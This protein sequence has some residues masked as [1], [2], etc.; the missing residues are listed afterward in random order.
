MNEKIALFGFNGEAMCFV[1]VLLNAL[2]MHDKGN[3]V[4][5]VVEGASVKALVEVAAQGHPFN[6]LYAK[7]REA[8][9]FDGACKA[10]SA[11]MGVLD[12][13]QALDM[14]LLADMSGHPSM[15]AYMERGYKIITF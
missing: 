14:P 1:H 6:A 13:V 9:L 11:K 3:D 12:A 2:D 8:G 15:A 4:L 7:A 5:I 10:C